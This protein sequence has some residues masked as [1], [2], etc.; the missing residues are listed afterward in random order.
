MSTTLLIILVGLIVIAAI[1]AFVFIEKRRTEK[2]RNRFGPEYDRAIHD[3]G[4]KARAEKALEHR[5]ERTASYPIRSLTVEELNRFSAE[6]RQ[7]QAHFV[8]NPPL[9]I[10]EADNLVCELMRT[11]GYP[12][13]DF[14]RRAEDLSV[15]HADVVRNYR[16]ARDIA[17]TQ[18]KGLATT[19]DLRQAMVH[20]RLLFDEL[21]ETHATATSRV[22]H[23]QR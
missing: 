18:Q 2:L 19:E 5:T 1:A 4:G 8:D 12:M 14:D 15:D 9:A 10:R 7:A 6:W 11:R 16:A 21:L 20:Y 17:M 13:A 22:L 23:Q 3:Y